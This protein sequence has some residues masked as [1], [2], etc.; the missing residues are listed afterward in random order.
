MDSFRIFNS[1]RIPHGTCAYHADMQGHIL[2]KDDPD[3]EGSP[4][5]G[6]CHCQILSVTV[7]L[8]E[9]AIEDGLDGVDFYLFTR[10][11]LPDNYLTQDEA[12]HLGWK[13]WL[14][15]LWAVLPGAVI[16]GGQYKNRDDRLP[17]KPGRI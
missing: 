3:V 5:H 11:Y 17:G 15:N 6:N 1:K 16:G 4:V 7:F 2:R 14:G 12:K 8:P 9:T 10:Q 13:R